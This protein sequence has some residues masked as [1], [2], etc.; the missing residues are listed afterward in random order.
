MTTTQQGRIDQIQSM[1]IKD[2]IFADTDFLR[3]A[4]GILK[5]SKEDPDVSKEDHK[6]LVTVYEKRV[7]ESGIVEKEDGKLLVRR[8]LIFLGLGYKD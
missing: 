1:E 6:T 7:E 3:D 5:E 2:E 4:E 8:T